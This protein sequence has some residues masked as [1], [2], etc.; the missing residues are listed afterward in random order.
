MTHITLSIPNEV[1]DAMKEHP[2]INW[3]AVA[4]ISIIEKTIT[5]KKKIKSKELLHL[6]PQ[7]VQESIMQANEKEAE[8]FSKKVR[9]AGLKRTKFLTQA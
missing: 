5:L 4:R 2:E 3:S 7:E 8:N 9:G 1:Y 6:L